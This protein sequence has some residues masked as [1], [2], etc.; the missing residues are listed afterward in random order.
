VSNVYTEVLGNN[1]SN[2][3]AGSTLQMTGFLDGSVNCACKQ[4]P[5]TVYFFGRHFTGSAL[6]LS[7]LCPAV[8]QKQ[9]LSTKSIHF[10]VALKP[11]TLGLSCFF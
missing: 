8:L 1:C 6:A 3:A 11:S 2:Q 7:F 9:K 10:G 5:L 4:P